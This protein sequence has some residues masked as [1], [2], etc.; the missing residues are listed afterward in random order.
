MDAFTDADGHQAR[1]RP[2]QCTLCRRPTFE[3]TAI[4]GPCQAHEEELGE[5]EEERWRAMQDEFETWA[6]RDDP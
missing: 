2:V 5:R 3:V 4:C 1:E 6:R